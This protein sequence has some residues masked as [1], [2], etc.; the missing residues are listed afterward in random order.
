MEYGTVITLQGS[1]SHPAAAGR[2]TGWAW[3]SC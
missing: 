2:V 3:P 1:V